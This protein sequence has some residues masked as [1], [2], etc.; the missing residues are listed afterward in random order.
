MRGRVCP[1]PAHTEMNSN[2]AFPE[3]DN[4]VACDSDSSGSEQGVTLPFPCPAGGSASAM[5]TLRHPTIIR[6][7]MHDGRM[8]PLMWSR[9]V[10]VT[11]TTLCLTLVGCTPDPAPVILREHGLDHFG[12]ETVAQYPMAGDSFTQG[13]E[14]D[15]ERLLVGTG[16]TGESRVYT[17]DLDGTEIRSVDLPPEYFGEGVT[18]TG[19]AIWQL[20]WRD[21]TAIKRDR[22]TLEEIGRTS[23]PG[24]G[25][26]LCSFGDTVVMSDGTDHLRL[27]DPDDLRELS[28]IPVTLSG[29]P[30]DRLNE[31]ECVEAN[32]R[33]SVLANV[34]TTTT[35]VRVD[36]D[37]GA[38]TAVI[39][40]SG[41]R[42]ANPTDPDDVLNGI[43]QVPGTNRLLLTGKRWG[44]LY[45]VTL[46]ESPTTDR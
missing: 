6:Y 33:R 37:D 40:A 45:E 18:D 9:S 20:T 13:L 16:I 41:L 26:G 22:D 21:G 35:I 38:V 17:S 39:D 5:I 23:Y 1:D 8:S 10:T 36:L 12:V 3:T 32:G 19:T 29:E 28:R 2:S 44:T 11:A 43:A 4:S 34:W 25:W 7:L 46:T 15:G 27:L 14:Y 31:L 24:E 30:M 42:D